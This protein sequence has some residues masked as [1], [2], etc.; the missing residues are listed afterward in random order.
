[1]ERVASFDVAI[2]DLGRLLGI[3]S[4]GWDA[5]ASCLIEFSDE[6]GIT[7]YFNDDHDGVYI[8]SIVGEVAA[9]APASLLGEVL[10]ANLFG[11][12]T[13]G[14]SFGLDRDN[15][16][17]Y[18]ARSV[19][20]GSVSGEYLHRCLIEMVDVVRRWQPKLSAASA[21]LGEPSLAS[22]ITTKDRY[23]SSSDQSNHITLHP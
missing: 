16:L 7:L 8:Y 5:D 22:A 10:E 9:D 17:L 21:G 23:Q 19:L 15:G 1:V 4:L 3:D 13:R 14:A 20:A 11:I 6:I 2:K 12:G 18:I